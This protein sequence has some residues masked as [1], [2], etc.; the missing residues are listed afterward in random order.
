VTTRQPGYRRPALFSIAQCAS[1]GAA[2]ALPRETSHDVYELIYA[3]AD[4][5]PGYD[6]YARYARRVK[7]ERRPLAYLAAQEDVYWAISCYLAQRD[8]VETGNVLEIGCGLGYLTYAMRASGFEATGLDLSREAVARARERYGPFYEAADA[9]QLAQTVPGSA[10]LVVMTEV[11]EHLPDPDAVL[12]AIAALLREGGEAVITTPNRSVHPPGLV[13]ET[14]APPV[15]L[16]WFTEDAMRA[17]AR[18]LGMQIRFLDFTPLNERF[19]PLV[20]GPQSSGVTRAATFDQSGR[21]L[22]PTGAVRRVLPVGL[23]YDVLAKTRARFIAL[24]RRWRKQ[25]DPFQGRRGTLCA[26]LTKS[27]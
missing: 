17:L 23:A 4:M 25:P 11:I 6:R 2:H 26:I 14:D 27:A 7:R 22:G 5:L 9:V 1:C 16:W 10:G 3:R 18:R 12:R 19:A 21:L 24:R 13:W 8:P 15:H 20:P